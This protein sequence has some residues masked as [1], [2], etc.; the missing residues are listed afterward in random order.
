MIS[1]HKQQLKSVPTLILHCI[2]SV[3]TLGLTLQMQAFI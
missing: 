2:Y 3:I 1:S